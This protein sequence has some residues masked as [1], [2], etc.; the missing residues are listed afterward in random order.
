MSIKKM[1]HAKYTTFSPQKK[2]IAIL[3]AAL[4]G[5]LFVIFLVKGCQAIAAGKQKVPP[6]A[7]MVRQGNH[8]TIPSHSRLRTQMRLKTVRS[9]SAPHR[10]SLSGNVEADPTQTVNILPPLTGRLVSIHVN[11]GDVVQ[12]NQILAVIRS[13]DLALAYSDNDKAKSMRNMTADALK[14]ARDVNRVGGNSTKDVQQALNTDLQALAE[15]QRTEARLKALGHH[16]FD[17]LT[18]KSPTKGRV[19]ALNYGIGSYITESTIALLSISN[20]ETVWVTANVPE[21]LSGI[22]A[23][24]QRVTIHLPAFPDQVLHG[25]VAFV[26]AFLD[27]DTRHNK[28]RIAIPNPDGKL[29]PNMYATVHVSIPQSHWVMIPISAVLMNDDTT[30]VYVET[31]PWTFQQRN[32][33]LGAED[34]NNV[35]ILSGLKVGERIAVRGGIFIND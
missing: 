19:T 3:L 8:I 5:L 4:L 7:I 31:S 28:T 12:K 9:S 32:V 29:Q 34:G 17:L 6:E 33:Q 25:K 35:R 2:T 22:I 10:V 15:L 13:P 11:L 23:K 1:V 24:N 27:A 26:N 14:R 18:I 16:T 30:S 21:N 20:L